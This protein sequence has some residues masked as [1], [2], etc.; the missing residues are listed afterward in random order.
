MRMRENDVTLGIPKSSYVEGS[1]N[2]HLN[3]TVLLST[4][5]ICLNKCVR[6]NKCNFMLKIL[7]KLFIL[8][9]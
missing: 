7:L 6:K 3:V 5:N 9:C 2:D 1:Q 4:Q 8:T